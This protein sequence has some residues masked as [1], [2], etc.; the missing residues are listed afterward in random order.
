[1]KIEI[2]NRI[3]FAELEK[4]LRRVPLM[5][6]AEDGSQI[7]IYKDARITL[8]NLSAE[9]VNPPTFYII[10]RNLQLQRDVRESLLNQYNIDLFNLNGALEIKNEQKEIWTL[11]PPIIEVVSRIV[12]YV[13]QGGEIDHRSKQIKILIPTLADGSH[14]GALARRLGLPFNAVY[15]SEIDEKHPT[16]YAHPNSWDKVQEVEDTP[17]TMSD[18]KLYRLEKH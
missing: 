9:E 15:I 14:R 5:A 13:P 16:Y 6:I 12:S 18:K 4:M 1:M 17:K 7:Y 10:K 11:T 8:K 2:L 3:T